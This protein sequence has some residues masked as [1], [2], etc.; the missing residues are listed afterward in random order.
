MYNLFT[1]AHA[2]RHRLNIE[3]SLTTVAQYSISCKKILSVNQLSVQNK[4]TT[5]IG[6]CGTLGCFQLGHV[7][8]Q[9][10]EKFR[11]D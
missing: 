8:A 1:H 11:L 2:V 7:A 5:T 6:G 4:E 10:H 9:E 3:T